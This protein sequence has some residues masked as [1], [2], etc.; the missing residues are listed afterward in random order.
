M[1]FLW[2]RSGISKRFL[3]SFYRISMGFHEMS[4]IFLRDFC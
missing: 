2:D 4:V 1:M 3:C